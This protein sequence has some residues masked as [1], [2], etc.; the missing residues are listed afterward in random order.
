MNLAVWFAL[1]VQF[2]QMTMTSA[3]GARLELP[4]LSSI[5]LPSAQR[6]APSALRTAAAAVSA[7]RFRLAVIPLLIACSGAGVLYFC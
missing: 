4:V 3:L 2:A 5:N 7:F 1:H 6:P